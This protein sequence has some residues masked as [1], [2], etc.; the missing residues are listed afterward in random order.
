MNP[1]ITIEQINDDHKGF[2]FNG[3]NIIFA[4]CKEDDEYY[5]LILYNDAGEEMG[6]I[7]TDKYTIEYI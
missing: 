5:L 4:S 7:E 1:V 3:I 2:T 6:S